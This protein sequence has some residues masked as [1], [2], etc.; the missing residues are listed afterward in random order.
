MFARSIDFIQ[1][2]LKQLIR[3]ADRQLLEQ[4]HEC[5]RKDEESG[6]HYGVRRIIVCLRLHRSYT[7]DSRRIYRIFREQRLIISI[8]SSNPTSSRRH[9]QA[10]QPENRVQ[11]HFTATTPHAQCPADIAG[12]P[13]FHG[14]LYLAAG[15]DCFDRRRSSTHGYRQATA[16]G[17]EEHHLSVYPRLQPATCL[18]GRRRFAAAG[19]SKKLWETASIGRCLIGPALFTSP[20]HGWTELFSATPIGSICE[21]EV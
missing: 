14:K 4:L 7:G 8:A 15:L 13:C 12:I 2:F 10:E 21:H 5:L 6:E 17:R 1:V 9:P 16:R 3:R 19:V 11:R 20:L 18:L